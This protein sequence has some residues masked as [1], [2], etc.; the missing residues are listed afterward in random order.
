MKACGIMEDSSG[1]RLSKILR[2][3]TGLVYDTRMLAHRNIHDRGEHPENPERIKA[4]FNKMKEEGIVSRCLRIQIREASAED[5]LRAHSL[6]YH[7][8]LQE[9]SAMD[10]EELKAYSKAFNSIYLSSE[11]AFCGRLAAGGVIE[12][13]K[14][15]W[16]GLVSNG[17][18][19]VRPPG[20]HAEPNEA[21]GFCLYNN[22]AV[23]AKYLQ[24]E[25]GVKKILIVDWDVHHGNGTQHIFYDNPDVLFISLHRYENGL[26]YPGTRAG[27]CDQVGTGAGV[28]RNVNIPW[29]CKGLGDAD[30]LYAFQR[31]VMPI[32]YEFNPDIV[33]ISAGF[34]AAE[35]DYIGQCRVTP[36]GFGQM[37]S[38]L[39]GLADGRVI[40]TLEGGYNVEAI[41]ECMTACAAVIVGSAPSRPSKGDPSLAA[42]ETV[43]KVLQIQSKF[44]KS[45]S[46]KCKNFLYD[47]LLLQRA[48]LSAG[49]SIAEKPVHPALSAQCSSSSLI[50]TVKVEDGG[51]DDEASY[52]NGRQAGEHEVKVNGRE[53]VT[54][55]EEAET[56]A[57]RV[58]AHVECS[59]M[60]QLVCS[61]RLSLLQRIGGSHVALQELPPMFDALGASL[62]VVAPNPSS[63][64]YYVFIHEPPE[65]RAYTKA[66]ENVLDCDKSF[67]RD[68]TLKYQQRWISEGRNVIDLTI[69]SRK[70]SQKSLL[71]NTKPYCKVEHSDRYGRS[72]KPE[73]SG[74]PERVSSRSPPDI[75]TSLLEYVCSS[76]A[77]RA[78]K[79]LYIIAG[80]FV[81][82]AVKLLVESTD[83]Q[84]KISFI[85]AMP[86]SS[87]PPSVRGRAGDSWYYDHS[88]VV[89]PC[90]SVA[91]GASIKLTRSFGK[92]VSSGIDALD[93]NMHE[94]LDQF[95][96]ECT[97]LVSEKSGKL[98]LAAPP[99]LPVADFSS[100]V[101]QNGKIRRTRSAS[102][103]RSTQKFVLENGTAPFLNGDVDQWS[104]KRRKR[105]SSNVTKS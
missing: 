32:A 46:P 13:C 68:T 52:A 15:V 101:L 45:L 104:T 105:Q 84:K 73:R 56:F 16:T 43:H 1:N 12:M 82:D 91:R 34:D 31:V 77:A 71:D 61:W 5:I 44:W 64:L 79:L 75:L 22:V 55:D 50:E 11:S 102:P 99:Q 40:V 20:H 33:L 85:C 97:A 49:S 76:A 89:V 54:S 21:M 92:C 88:F 17:V 87:Q 53:A 29:P 62:C 24:K 83:W 70:L 9:S 18:C 37:T 80:P 90:T 98:T 10:T 35:G 42:L 30:Y 26:F 72:A 41:A 69:D 51:G 38:L 94:T 36:A 58:E 25:H 27:S 2:P 95:F 39:K 78:S 48:R 6:S 74:S 57:K 47:D 103:T 19:V 100:S 96:E 4:I 7:S 59:P 28:G 66:T 23:G 14:A 63:S 8:S 67:F 65:I 3:A 60:Y 81:S 86:S 93:W